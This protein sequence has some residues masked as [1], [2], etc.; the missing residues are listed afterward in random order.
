MAVD[1]G[2]GSSGHGGGSGDGASSRGGGGYSGRRGAHGRR[3]GGRE[4]VAL[5]AEEVL[6]LVVLRV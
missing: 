2:E 3:G 6:V 1:S 5:R 4:V